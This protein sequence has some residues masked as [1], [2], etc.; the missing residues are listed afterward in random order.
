MIKIKDLIA[1]LQ[2]LGFT[3][4]ESKVYLEL[5]KLGTLTGYEAAKQAGIPRP[6]AYSALQGL[7]E[8][9][10]A[11]K[12]QGEPNKY[13]AIAVNELSYHIAKK[14]KD[15]LGYLQKHIQV[16]QPP[17]NEPFITIEGDTN[18][19]SKISYLIQKAEENVYLDAWFE[20]IQ[21]LQEELL[22]AKVRGVEVVLISVG[23]ID[24]ALTNV[25]DHGR[26]EEW[27]KDGVRSIRLIID[28]KEVLTG[29][30]GRSKSSTALYSKNS[31]LIE[32]VQESLVHDIM[33]IEIKKAFEPQLTKK[34]GKNLNK[35]TKS[36]SCLRHNKNKEGKEEK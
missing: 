32:L 25:Y 2:I 17:V 13:M 4:N 26:E 34:F 29:E 31:S 5:N 24:L 16:N 3:E 33:L 10:A 11:L 12:T 19:L 9:G 30:V 35:L 36:I 6:N 8:K 27:A 7:V 1:R 23:T 20:E 18:I 14:T 15:T 28:S 21:E 22:T